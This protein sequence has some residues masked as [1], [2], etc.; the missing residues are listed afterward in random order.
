MYA[1]IGIPG[2]LAIMFCSSY[3]A[4]IPS[5]WLARLTCYPQVPKTPTVLLAAAAAKAKTTQATPE[6]ATPAEDKATPATPPKAKT[7]AYYAVPTKGIYRDY[8]AEVL[9]ALKGE[10]GAVHC[11]FG[12]EEEAK[13]WLSAYEKGEPCESS[14]LI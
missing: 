10:K 5:Y 8:R 6:G 11:K 1:R 13:V 14:M 2:A 12:T 4:R 7:K 3:A 9:P